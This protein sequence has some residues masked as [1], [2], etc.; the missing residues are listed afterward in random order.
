MLCKGSLLRVYSHL[1][2]DGICSAALLAKT[3]AQKNLKHSVH[4]V[5]QVDGA[6]IEGLK[7]SPGSFIFADLGS[8]HWS[9]IRRELGS[10][11]IVLD[12]HRPR[13][14]AQMG[15]VNPHFFGIDGGREISGA[16]VVY[17][18][19]R[20]IW[21]G[22]ENY[23]HIAVIGAIGDNQEANGFLGPNR[24]ILETAVRLNR[25]KVSLG[26]RLFGRESRS[27]QRV[28]VQ[29]YDFPIPG[30]T[31]SRVGA[32]ALLKKIGIDRMKAGRI[33]YPDLESDQAQELASLILEKRKT[34]NDPVIGRIY[35]LEESVPELRDA[36]SYSTV[37][38]ACGRTGQG[39]TGVK[40]LLGSMPDKKKAVLALREYRKQIVRMMD[41]YNS[42][43]HEEGKKFLFVDA[44]SAV[45]ESMAGTF[46]S[47]VS[48]T[49]GQG[50]RAVIVLCSC[51]DRVKVSARTQSGD[52]DL[53]ASI[54]EAAHAVGG[55]SGGH[56]NAA[57][58]YIG[59]RVKD[60]FKRELRRIFS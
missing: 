18:F 25:V 54:R 16:G 42:G 43:I 37:L 21:P 29:S 53:G 4:I 12:H 28:L 3:L 10:R 34:R 45:P 27:L 13:G 57:G 35:T 15:H 9:I 51:M 58:A 44:G 5:P 2:C 22:I 7:N 19:C 38:N 40:A 33:R 52:Y 59:A 48:R 6:L 46:A 23:A 26:L 8:A 60:A 31:G 17:M 11:A 1:D 24:E 41:W 55:E 56:R 39:M 47:I 50:H 14:K 49:P 20:R 32:A 30:V 36:R